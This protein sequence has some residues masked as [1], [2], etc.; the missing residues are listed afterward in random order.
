MPGRKDTMSLSTI[1]FTRDNMKTTTRKFASG[2]FESANLN[3]ADIDGNNCP[4]L[5]YIFRSF[6]KVARV[7]ASKQA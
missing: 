7:K 5:T 3:T 1:D 6:T 2:R 4:Y